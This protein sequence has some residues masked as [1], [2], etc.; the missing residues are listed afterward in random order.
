MK[1]FFSCLIACLFLV[2]SALVF[3]TCKKAY[4]YEGGL[5]AIYTFN[6]AGGS[7]TNS[8]LSGNY[9][10]D[11]TL[12]MGDSVVLGVDVTRAGTYQIT[13]NTADGIQFSGSGN[14]ADTGEQVVTLKG[15]GTLAAGGSFSFMPV[16][17]SACSFT[18]DVTQGHV[19]YANYTLSGEPNSCSNSA[20]TGSYVAGQAFTLAN[21]VVVNVDVA[22]PG[23]YSITT[24]TLDGFSF[25]ASGT[26]NTTGT[27]QVTLE[28]T[29]IPN[30]PLNLM[31]TVSGDSTNC[32]FSVGVVNPPPLA[33]YVLESGSTGSGDEC[34]YAVSGSYNVNTEL[35]SSN[36]VSIHVYVSVVGNF[37]I[38]TPE[39]G[40]MVFS[41]TGAFT[42]TG[43]QTVSL[44]GSGKP[45]QQGTFQLVPAIVGP[46]PIGGA[47]CGFAIT[48]N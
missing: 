47:S 42:S 41:Y 17:D 5:P 40:G 22:S 36:S 14:F 1:K 27:V 25:A 8:N 7:C 20:V 12:G 15:A 11:S 4:S 31:F 48:V 34:I 19:V 23:V 26:F 18:V 38:A 45:T 6:G 44:L 46:A 32:S 9:F 24:D 35:S 21:A 43:E 10:I 13:T 30:T 2:G 33:T 37:T 3:S 29:G 16:S 28:A 39:V